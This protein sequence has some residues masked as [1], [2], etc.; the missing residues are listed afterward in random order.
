LEMQSDLRI[1]GEAESGE[2][3]VKLAADMAPDVAL[4]DLLLAGAMDGVATT[5]QIKRVSPRTQ[6]IVLTSLTGEEKYVLPALQ[7]GA[8]SYL[9][10][11]VSGTELL[12][13]V[14]RAARGEATLHGKVAAQ[15]MRLARGETSA[16]ERT[17]ATP[18]AELTEREQEVLR[19]LAEGM[20]NA[21]IADAL[22]VSEKTVKSHVSNILGK[23][24]LVQRAQAIALAWREGFVRR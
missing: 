11:D 4:V 5:E 22:F 6:V 7:A 18:F 16:G 17:T 13:A 15:V 14:R 24:Q 8:I 3:A 20:S 19:L 12:T 9:F 2:Q 23:L 1:V 21:E 10:K